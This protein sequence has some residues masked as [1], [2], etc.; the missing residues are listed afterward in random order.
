MRMGR[1][2]E[3]AGF[4]W[5]GSAR[6]WYWSSLLTEQGSSSRV[7]RRH[8]HR[9]SPG[10]GSIST[11]PSLSSRGRPMSQLSVVLVSLRPPLLFRRSGACQH[12][13]HLRMQA[14]PRQAGH[15]CQRERCSAAASS[16]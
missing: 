4:A 2:S 16:A 1:C 5:A 9:S 8:R 14:Y 3:V 12:C 15:D 10:V 13:G 6:F 11:Q 7:S